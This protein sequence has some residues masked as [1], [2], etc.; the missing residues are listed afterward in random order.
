M[1]RSRTPTNVLDARGAFKKD[2]QRRRI[3]P[4]VAGPLTEPPA[5]LSQAQIDCWKEIVRV[6]PIGAITESDRITLEMAACLLSEFRCAR[7][8]FPVNKL[9]RLE[10]L[11]GKFGMTP[12]DRSRVSGKND[13]PRGNPFA[14]L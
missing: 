11:L 7:T 13:K 12:A 10:T 2:P 4:D 8:D 1:A 14:D 9:L 6:A 3:D 5:G